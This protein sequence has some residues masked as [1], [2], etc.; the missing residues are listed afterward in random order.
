MVG[1]RDYDCVEPILLEQLFHVREYIGNTESLREGA[2]LYTIVVANRDQRR[3][4]DLREKGKMRQLRNRSGSY[5]RNP[6]VGRR[7]PIRYVDRL[8][9]IRSPGAARCQSMRPTVVPG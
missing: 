7:C 5:E 2:R 6:A 1:R 9:A 3:S 4:L 8:T